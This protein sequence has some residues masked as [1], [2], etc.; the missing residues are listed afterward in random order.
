M[1]DELSRIYFDGQPVRL[2][3][4]EARPPLSRVVRAGGK[5]PGQTDIHVLA[6]PK[7][8]TGHPLADEEI[9]DRTVEPMK[10]IYLRSVPKP[11][12]Q[13]APM[14]NV[15][16][17]IAQ[18]GKE[19]RPPPASDDTDAT[20]GRAEAQAFAEAEAEERQEEARGQEDA[21]QDE[22]EALQDEA[23]DRESNG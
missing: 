2:L 23:D 22:A 16:P 10:P 1:K 13:P 18:L 11:D 5:V 15:D 4:D 12:A 14:S 9:L 19:P 3:G 6:S 17:V 7:A 21:M 8:A 20:P